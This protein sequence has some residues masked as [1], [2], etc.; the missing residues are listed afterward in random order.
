MTSSQRHHQHHHQQQQQ[1]QRYYSDN[2]D[3]HKYAGDSINRPKPKSETIILY[4]I[5]TKTDLVTRNKLHVY[6]TMTI[7]TDI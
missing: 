7:F 4:S 5:E 2:N 1:Q 3:S 6:I